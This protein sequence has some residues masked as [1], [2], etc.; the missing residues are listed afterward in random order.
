[1]MVMVMVMVRMEVKEGL[2]KMV[3]SQPG[4]TST[5]G[6]TGLGEMPS[7]DIPSCQWWVSSS[8]SEGPVRHAL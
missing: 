3:P 8:Q 7:H 5:Y 4:V 2:V 1:V 6:G